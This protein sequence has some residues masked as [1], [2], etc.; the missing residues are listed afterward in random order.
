MAYRTLVVDDTIFYRRLIK[1]ILNEIDD[2]EVIGTAANGKMALNRIK[3]KEP[4]LVTLDVEMPVMNGLEVLQGINEENYE[5]ECI[6]VSSK[7]HRGGEITM[8]ALEA[9]A[10]DFIPKPDTD[11]AEENRKELRRELKE[12]IKAFNRHHRLSGIVK[13]RDYSKSSKKKSK[14]KKKQ[15]RK[16]KKKSRPEKVEIKKSTRKRGEK[17]KAI[18]LG[19]STGGPKALSTIIPEF[20]ARIGVPIFI[21]QHMPPVFT[22]SLAKSLNKKSKLEIKEAEDGEKVSRDTIYIA[23]GGKHMKVTM[24]EG[25]VKKIKITDDPKENNCKPAV[26]YTFRSV[27]RVYGSKTTA[28]IMTGMGSDGKLGF[29][30]LKGA[31]AVTIAQ[32]ADT[33][34]VYGMPKSVIEA[35]LVDVISPL[36]E[37]PK[38]ILK[39]I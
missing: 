16:K 24:G 11:S 39:T 15:K 20:P 31:G 1:E 10:F 38:E 19:I 17:S 36:Q 12:K 18:V 33:C 30:V 9:G 35:E 7:T 2:I 4:D 13:G 37:I 26:D 22:S 8:K 3:N 5:T 21:V 14:T 23:P 25:L 34:T 28:V 32:S 27:A 6:M 29:T